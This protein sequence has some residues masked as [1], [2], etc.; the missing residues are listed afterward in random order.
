MRRTTIFIDKCQINVLKLKQISK[1]I[2]YIT[3][4]F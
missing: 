4:P 1:T 2:I 3:K